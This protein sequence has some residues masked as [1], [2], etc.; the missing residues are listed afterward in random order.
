[1]AGAAASVPGR[2]FRL[3]KRRLGQ[4]AGRGDVF[5]LRFL[6]EQ[7]GLAYRHQLLATFTEDGYDEYDFIS[8]RELELAVEGIQE[9]RYIRAIL[10]WGDEAF[11]I[12]HGRPGC[13][14]VV[15]R[16]GASGGGCPIFLEREGDR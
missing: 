3:G 16:T 1:M 9:G 4:R 12:F 7:E 15:W 10:E 8:K 2:F 14:K 13:L 11:S 5:L 6:A